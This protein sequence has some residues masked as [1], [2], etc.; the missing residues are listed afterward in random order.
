MF[1]RQHQSKPK[2]IE[3]IFE[4]EQ[5]IEKRRI[6]YEDDTLQSFRYWI[7]DSAPYCSSL[8]GIVD[9]TTTASQ[10]TRTTKTTLSS[11]FI[12]TTVTA[13][14]A[15]ETVFSTRY[16]FIGKRDG[17][18]P[19]KAAFYEENPYAYSVIGDDTNA[20]IAASYSSA[21]SCLSLRPSTVESV[22]L[23]TS[24]RTLSG[25]DTEETTA[26]VI[27][28]S[29]TTT[30]ILTRA[31]NPGPVTVT[32]TLSIVPTP[33]PSTNTSSMFPL[34]TGPISVGTSAPSGL[35][36]SVTSNSSL[37]LSTR[38]GSS[39][40]RPT[41][42]PTLNVTSYSV[43]NFTSSAFSNSTAPPPLVTGPSSGFPL[44]PTGNLSFSFLPSSGLPSAISSGFP[45]LSL[46]SSISLQP[47]SGFPVPSTNVTV[48][49]L[50]S[51]GL[52]SSIGNL[53]SVITPSLTPSISIIASD[54]SPIYPLNST[55]FQSPPTTT[56]VVTAT[57]PP[58]N[59]SASTS[60]PTYSLNL[61]ILQPPPT[62][63]I[64]VT[65]IVPPGNT[66]TITSATATAASGS[67]VPSLTPPIC[68]GLNGTIIDLSD[69]Q[70]YGVVCETEYGGATDIGLTT[71]TFQDCIQSCAV[72][73]NGFSAV[74]CRAVTYFDYDPR[75]PSPN[76][77]YKNLAALT[78]QRYNKFAQSAVLLNA[79]ST[80]PS[81]M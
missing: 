6:C 11:T 50:A 34:S 1:G 51:S 76:C 38:F 63:S 65:A 57:I 24:T 46:N 54:G 22:T 78:D 58:G 43:P 49:P 56:V 4:R 19:T 15:S 8:L 55:I 71:R 41:I 72:A 28:T 35:L 2:R 60:A 20:S 9:F 10:T 59:L 23:T 37:Y 39:G 14:V 48:S 5:D 61:T 52:P 68:P 21:C 62:T 75:A 32:S 18:E 3:E 25:E 44:Y 69:G 64:S 12:T 81:N 47:T 29:G 53:S 36:P 42:A 70:E 67:A 7:I 77:F 40:T 66:T 31:G 73:N 26:T 74:R 17:P 13:T 16:A 80:N 79:V 45:T 33:L 30:R 27:V